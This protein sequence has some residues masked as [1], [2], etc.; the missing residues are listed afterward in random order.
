MKKTLV[1]MALL[2][3]AQAFAFEASSKKEDGLQPPAQQEEEKKKTGLSSSS[4]SLYTDVECDMSDYTCYKIIM[5][6]GRQEAIAHVM[7]G[8]NAEKS[9]VLVQAIDVYKKLVPEA[10][11]LTDEEV[12]YLLATE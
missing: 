10:Q 8:G 5:D 7:A 4:E 12:I 2:M 1:L 3:S 9:T 11:N 6:L